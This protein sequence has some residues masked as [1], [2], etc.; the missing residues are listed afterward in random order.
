MFTGRTRNWAFIVYP[1]SAPDCF[2]SMLDDLHVPIFISPLHNPVINEN[3]EHERKEHYHVIVMFDSVKTYKQAKEVADIVNGSNP[4][5][6]NAIRGYARYI[7]HL[8][9]P[10]KE[11]FG[12]D[13][14]YKVRSLAGADYFE[15]ISLVTDRLQLIQEMI[16][17]IE[18]Y[19]CISF[20]Q[21]A[22]FAAENNDSWHRA[23]TT[24]CTVYMKNY[25]QSRLWSRERGLM[26]LYD[27]DSG[28]EIV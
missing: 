23:L 22:K 27:H 25:L 28:E 11:Q 4:I 16:V 8:D 15:T 13:A 24:S 18:K 21:L 5:P 10:E 3:D 9:N 17:W 14:A 26:H 19:D 2:V 20:Y 1:D 6:I 12:S 7:C